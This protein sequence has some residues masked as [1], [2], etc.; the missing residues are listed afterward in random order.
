[1]SHDKKFMIK[2]MKIGEVK[3]ILK[4]LDAYI[5]HLMINPDSLLAKIFGVFTLRKNGFV[6]QHIMLMENT[7]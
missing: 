1:M 6:P 3:T 7:L 2:T 5:E 4:M